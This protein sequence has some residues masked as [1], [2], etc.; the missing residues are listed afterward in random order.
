MKIV[1]AENI[2][3]AAESVL[4]AADP[5]WEIVN[6]VK[7]KGPV[8]EAV[9][10]ADALLIRTATKVTPEFLEGP[11]RLRVIARAGVGVD[12][13]NLDAATRRGIVVM[14]VPGGNTI[15]V[16][17]Q[18]MAFLCMLARHIYQATTS[19]KQGKW[20]KKKLTGTELRGK[21]LG[22]VGLG[23]VGSAVARLAQAYQMNVIACD[24]YVSARAA[25][26]RGVKLIGLEEVLGSCDYLTLHCSLTEETR[27]MINAR[28]LALTR[29]GVRVVNCSRGE[30]LVADDLLAAL[31]SGHV[32]GAAVDVFDPEPPGAS[33]L[34]L[35][36]EVIVTPHIGGSTE[37][38]LEAIG[39]SVAEQVRDYLLTGIPRNA[40]NL[41]ALPPEEMR[42]I[43]PY[44]ELGGKLGSF[45][46]QIAGAR[47]EEVRISYDGA[48]EQSSTYLVKNAVLAGILRRSL[49]E[50]VNLINAGA[51]A[52][53]R[54]IEVVEMRSARRA[55]YVNT[56]GIAVR[57][58]TGS[59]SVLG[60]GDFQGGQRI[61]G[62][63]D[64]DVEAPLRGTILFIRNQD[65]PGVIGKVGTLL[66][67]RGIN[68]ANFALGRSPERAEAVA[69]VNVDQSISPADLSELRSI[70][71]IRLA[72]VVEI[73]ETARGE[74][75]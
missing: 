25:A 44:L 65:V 70:A 17:E 43:Q 2:A 32:A 49:S 15:S 39:T 54:G 10:D 68:I 42:R 1:I 21:T 38:A 55:A 33:P 13:I 67:N 6:L 50:R 14:N 29:P 24:P 46:G 23:R 59:S 4:H 56:L 53:E 64:I 75:N 73:A 28:A 7:T 27:G 20:E 51:L 9:I 69:V 63:E 8:A 61:L 30:V 22:I 37:E 45:L 48:L 71:A 5:S 41:P 74:S 31:E 18:T 3:E 62:I 36:P 40:V 72:T 58:D 34:V 35:H 16:A 47:V 66:G 11:K 57:T 12:N 19:M 52:T 26:E 60:M